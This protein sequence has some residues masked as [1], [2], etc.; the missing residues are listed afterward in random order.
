MDGENE[1]ANVTEPW[2]FDR[3]TQILNKNDQS[4]QCNEHQVEGI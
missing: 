4:E 2:S 1:Y 3:L